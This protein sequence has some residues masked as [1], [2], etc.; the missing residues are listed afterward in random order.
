MEESFTANSA[1]HYLLG[2]ARFGKL[3]TAEQ[4]AEVLK[5]QAEQLKLQREAEAE[6]D[7]MLAEAEPTTKAPKSTGED[8]N[9]KQSGRSHSSLQS[10]WLI[11]AKPESK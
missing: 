2:N 9:A 7:A 1:K 11:V 3:L 8:G 4:K 10:R 5:A 6:L